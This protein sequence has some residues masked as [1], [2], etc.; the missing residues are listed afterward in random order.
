MH[1][2][3]ERGNKDFW[4]KIDILLKPLGG[5][6]TG[7]ALAAVG[8]FTT[9]LLEEQQA[10]QT[11]RLAKQQT[12]ET[13][14]RL[15]T[16]IMTSREKA[17]SDLRKEMF[18]SIIAAFLDPEKASLDEK[19]LALELLAYN[20]HDV[21]DLSPLFKHVA[22][23]IDTSEDLNKDT[24][25]TLNDQLQRVAREVIDKQLATLAGGGQIKQFTLKFSDFDEDYR[26]ETVSEDDFLDD[27]EA[28]ED[29]FKEILVPMNIDD[30]EKSGQR[31]IYIEPL[32][33]YPDS[34]EIMIKLESGSPDNRLKA[35]VDVMFKVGFFDFPMIDNTRVSHAQRIGI[36]LTNFSN[37]HAEI[38]LVYFPASRASLKEKPFYDEVIN[39]L[40]K[41]TK[42]MLKRRGVE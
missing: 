38:A 13:N 22:N 23:S 32:Y 27:S 8:Y 17:D 4:D 2:H 16:E 7:L 30:P 12:E 6:F 5:L 9:N 26:E 33:V 15:Y 35:E 20:F 19:V 40:Q 21:I 3:S 25:D 29:P 41:T 10:Q 37:D 31:Y 28:D 14:R 42:D 18:N 1:Q 11:E 36:A 39:E 34:S 24:K